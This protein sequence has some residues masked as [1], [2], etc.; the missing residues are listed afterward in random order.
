MS[1]ELRKALRTGL[2]VV[3]PTLVLCL[4]M[5]EVGL[6]ALGQL[7]SNA[8]EGMFE[9]NGSTYRLRANLTKRL[10]TPSYTCTVETNS[11]GLRD[12]KAGE[13]TLGPAPYFAFVGDSITF[14]NGLDYDETFV[15]AFASIARSR[16]FDALNLAIGG[17]RFADQEMVLNDFLERVPQKPAGVVVVFTHLFITGFDRDTSRLIVK[18]GYLFDKDRWVLPFVLV[19]LGDASSAYNF[20]RDGIRRIQ[21]RTGAA[22]KDAALESLADFSRTSPWAEAA[23]RNRFLTRLTALD[24]LIR[25]AGAAPIYVYMPTSIDLDF[26]DHLR[27]A[28]VRG[29]AYDFGR[30]RDLLADHAQRGA[31]AFVDLTP[32]LMAMHDSG[33]VLT[34]LQD[35][36][37][38]A[39]AS[40]A[41]A[42]ALAAA[43][44]PRV[45]VTGVSG[46]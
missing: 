3:A 14:G 5:L 26:D 31:I 1:R 18:R 39:E 16:N 27:A 42:N 34:F 15:G 13:R 44:L 30:F 7:P 36:H 35:P 25:S 46:P 11:F 24:T 23:Q 4:V 41:I 19:A 40:R 8:T 2:L 28:G 22:A 29:D 33:K 43:L 32:T 9:K 21:G 38:N 6:R 17:H 45:A 37:Y 20:F 12:R 10:R